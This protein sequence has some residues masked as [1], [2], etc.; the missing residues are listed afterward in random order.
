MS[1]PCILSY[2]GS[3]ARPS[4]PF[5]EKPDSASADTAASLAARRRLT[6][7]LAELN[8]A[9]GKTDSGGGAQKATKKKKRNQ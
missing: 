1:S 3:F 5:V 2:V 9:G 4:L 6:A 8:P 7:V